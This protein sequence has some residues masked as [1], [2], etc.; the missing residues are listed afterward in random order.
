MRSSSRLGLSTGALAIL[1]AAGLQAQAPPP[2]LGKISFPSSAKP[3]AQ[4]A[5]VTG[6]KALHN[7]EFDQAYD[8]FLEVQKADP[9]FALGYWGE[10]LSFNHPLWAEQDLNAARKALNKLGK[11]P[12]E[13]AQ[14]A[15]QGKERSLIEAADILFGQGDKLTRDIA[16]SEALQRLYE[17]NP[18]DHEIAT[19]YALSLLGTVRPGDGGHKRQALA[20]TIALKVFRENPEHPGAAHLIIHAFDDPEL[21]MLG[22]EAARAYAKIAPAAPHATH[23]PTHI[24]VQLGM[25]D[26]VVTSNEQ[27]Y[28]AAA[29]LA[30]R[31]R[32]PR[33]REDFHNLAWLE[34][35]YLQQGRVDKAKETLA[36]AR[37]VMTI[38]S[39]E[40]VRSGYETM[41]ARYV[42]ETERWNEMPL[43]LESQNQHVIFARGL[44]A[45]KTGNLPVAE[46]SQAALRTMREKI[47]KTDTSQGGV[48]RAKPLAIMEKEVAAAIAQAKNDTATAERLLKEAI[49]I[50]ATM[51]APSGPPDPMKPALEMYGELLLDMNRQKDALAYFE[52]ALIRMPKRAAS[53][54]GIERAQGRR[55]PSGQ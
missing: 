4:S 42:I 25:W 19:L 1:V 14:K 24:F 20:A 30:E 46:R 43:T 16:Y 38:D 47:E 44:A 39:S 35:G 40:R 3:A 33:G 51:D 48:V 29:A 26:D 7:F 34:Y 12:E 36:E 49:A 53:L 28:A 37:K 21:A 32:L 45:A 41:H 9:A 55:I 22:L 5:F 52:Q 18:N 50:E 27:A 13:R 10:A 11:T 6:V 15:P 2:E 8:A 54:H 17:Q 23:M 31:K